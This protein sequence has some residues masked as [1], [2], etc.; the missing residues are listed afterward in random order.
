[1]SQFRVYVTPEALA[2]IKALPGNVRQR[3]RQTIRELAHQPQPPRSKQLEV[4]N[5]DR[6]FISNSSR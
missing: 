6:Q 4:P 2:E 3:I 5:M 1:M